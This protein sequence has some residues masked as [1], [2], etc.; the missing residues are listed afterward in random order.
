VKLNR[1]IKVTA[2]AVAG[3]ATVLALSSCG[4]AT[5]QPDQ[6]GLY[7]N[8]GW[9]EGNNFGHIVEPGTSDDTFAWNDKVVYLPT[10]LRTWNITPD[11]GGDQKEPIV[12]PTADGV[13]V[14]VWLQA[15]FVLNSNFNDIDG[16]EGGTIRK[17]WEEIGRRYEVHTNKGWRNMMLVTVVPAL[18]KAT[19]DT[20]RAYEA[21]PLVYNTDGIYDEV[22]EAIGTRFLANLVRLSG[23]NFFCGPT[24]VRG[25]EDTECP[26]PEL[27][28]RDVDFS[29]P[30]IQEARDQRRT[31]QELAQARLQEAQ[32]HLEAQ[33]RL[34]EAINDPA[35]LEYLKAQMQLEAAQA[36]AGSES[37]TFIQGA[38]V[39]PTIPA[40]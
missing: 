19:T 26:D 20:V 36:C 13:L 18:E 21:D 7:Y 27:I 1:P 29:N 15:N 22:Q 6:I 4:Y 2:L 32:G 8:Q 3:L 17:F 25:S 24:L 9:K 11:D 16:Y 33:E 40:R 14:H 31:E 30:A 37:C 23:G 12:V 39:T 35:Y 28:L 38:G 5:P 34:N 10:S